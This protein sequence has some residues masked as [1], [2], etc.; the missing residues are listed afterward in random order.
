MRRCSDTLSL[1]FLLAT[2]PL[3][4]LADAAE[5]QT[6]GPD[7]FAPLAETTV[8]P[9]AEAVRQ[10][11]VA[12]DLR[13]LD[14]ARDASVS[15][16][17]GGTGPREARVL[18]LNLFDDLVVTGVIDHTASTLSGGYSL[19]GHVVGEP[20][21]DLVLVVNGDI[22]VG[23]VATLDGRYAIESTGGG[24]TVSEVRASPLDC[25]VLPAPSADR[26][27]NGDS[28]A[29]ASVPSGVRGQSEDEVKDTTVEIAA[30]FGGVEPRRAHVEMLIAA[31]NRALR[32]SGARV[33]L[34]L[35]A[36][37]YVEYDTRDGNSSVIVDLERFRGTSDGYMDEV[38]TIR[39]QVAA[40][41]MVLFTARKGA[42]A[43]VSPGAENAFF[44]GGSGSS[45]FVH[46][47]GHTLGLLNHDR[48]DS[49][50]D[51]ECSGSAFG[52]VNPHGLNATAPR[53]RRWRTVMASH[54]RCG[55]AGYGCRT[56]DRFSNPDQKYPDANGDPL[57]VPA[58]NT[59]KGWDGPADAVGSINARRE[60][61][62]GFYSAPAISLSFGAATYTATEG[63]QAATVTV[64]LS[65]APT[66]RI[67]VPLAVS[68]ATEHDYEIPST[69]EFGSEET[70]K[71]FTVKAVDDA[72]DES[73]EEVEVSLGESLLRGVTAAGSTKVTLVDN[74]SS[75]SDATVV[76]VEITSS[77]R[78][79]GFYLANDEVEAMVRFSREVSVTGAP[80]LGLKLAG[81]T[82]WADYRRSSGEALWFAYQVADGDLAPDGVGIGEDTLELNGG[83]IRSSDMR[84]AELDHAS[85]AADGR[86]A[87]DTVLPAVQRA[88]I[89]YDEIVL[90]FSEAFGSGD[91]TYLAGSRGGQ[92]FEVTIGGRA[93]RVHLASVKS[94]SGSVRL[95]GLS[96]PAVAGQTVELT[97][98]PSGVPM[99]DAAGNRTPAFVLSGADI[100]NRSPAALYDADRDGLIDVANLAQLDAIRYDLGGDGFPTQAEPYFRAFRDGSPR[101]YCY[102]GC[103]GYELVTDLD[104]DTNGNGVADAGDEYW[105]GGGG[106]EPIGRPPRPY[107]GDFDGG[108][109]TV[110][111][112]FIDRPAEDGVGLF[113]SVRGDITMQRVGLIGVDVE[114][115]DEV[116]SLAGSL[117]GQVRESFATGQVT[118]SHSVG[119]LVGQTPSGSTP[120]VERSYAAVTVEG[121]FGV[122]GLVGNSSSSIYSSYATGTVTNTGRGSWAGTLYGMNHAGVHRS[123]ATGRVIGAGIGGLGS[124]PNSSFVKD[125]YWDSTTSGREGGRSTV[126]LRS[127]TGSEGIY[128]EWSDDVWHFGSAAQYPAL[129]VAFDGAGGA[130][131]Q[132]FGYQ[133]RTGPTLWAVSEAGGVSLTWTGVNTGAW[134]PAP[135]VSYR[136][137]R[138]S[139]GAVELLAEDIADLRYVDS[140]VNDEA[141]RY[142]VVAVVAGGEAARSAWM[143]PG[144]SPPPPPVIGG[145]GGGGGA[146]PAPDDEDGDGDG[147][148]GGGGGG[149]GDGGSGGVG[150]PRAR[151]TTNADCAGTFCR[152]RTGVAVRFEDA[153]S[154]SV[155]SRR[156]DF[157]DGTRRQG[158]PVDHA[159]SSPGFYEVTLWTSDGTVEST[160]SR[161]FLVEAADPAGTCV[162][163]E[164][165]RCLLDSRYAVT[166]DWR[167]AGDG[168]GS[169]SVVHSGTNDS[170][171]FQFFGRDNWEVLIKVLEGCALNGHVWV[172]GAST[173]DLGYVIRVTDTV[174]GT[175]REYGNEPGTPAPAITDS[176]AFAEACRR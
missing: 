125:S 78:A 165:T 154:G 156:W 2:L 106:W 129:K 174:T 88:W 139:G 124:V 149:G 26:P 108:G 25:Q 128:A 131:W 34:E 120:R 8:P 130:T 5:G 99:H 81:S 116:G 164:R 147:D 6:E 103:S 150:P 3:L 171:L 136:I 151:I 173:T 119:G 114:G 163:D 127:P 97:F 60:T 71:T 54:A 52:Y 51:E 37:E 87:V 79:S 45:N 85:V 46:E 137:F 157:G 43:Y 66:R 170:G 148:D 80:R 168:G 10:R 21:S 98:R 4:P 176:T 121:E 107:S 117:Q 63:G 56:L 49:C 155:R 38:H 94:Q 159:W 126:D 166:V 161:T 61:V 122:G 134:R 12:I 11:L 160:A 47:M 89:D 132:E 104:F 91:Y 152:A 100:E 35:V 84:P 115:G 141:V 83:S 1:V 140:G 40:D 76:S 145:G 30:I 111:N 146:S 48:Y 172:F 162:A 144:E 67:S 123:Y 59:S 142:Q 36:T 113:G 55:N 17:G 77:S 133:L 82:R 109:H 57:G 75:T 65:A 13:Q 112:L 50:G 105:N 68:G 96:P 53:S 95:T 138:R 24:V 158:A 18:R 33:Q 72:I 167:N 27:P 29:S 110:R 169:G 175:V 28:A 73:N 90:E 70:V 143:A 64:R 102:W 31:A 39:R 22:V 15:A 118:G 42:V 16:A 92:P 69:V 9:G 7:L 153:S 44:Y 32:T 135:A 101:L 74:D 23:S 58:A 19:S 20:H 86:H 41:L 14:R 93:V 62:A